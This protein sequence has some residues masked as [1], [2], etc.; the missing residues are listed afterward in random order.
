MFESIKVIAVKSNAIEY[1]NSYFIENDTPVYNII[2]NKINPDL[3]HVGHLM[4]M[5][6]F[7]KA[8]VKLKIPYIVSL[9]DF[10]LICHKAQ[11]LTDRLALCSGPEQGKKC[12]QMCLGLEK[13]YYEQ[14]FIEANKILRESRA[15]IVSSDFLHSI[16]RLFWIYSFPGPVLVWAH[17]INKQ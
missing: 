12:K 13:D 14:R 9:T 6:A 10:W 2:I 5:N 7:L 4:Y 11:M 15:N 8:G 3:I 17:L 1:S 16:K